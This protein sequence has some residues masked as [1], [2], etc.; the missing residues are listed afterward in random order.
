MYFFRLHF[1]SIAPKKTKTSLPYRTK[2]ERKNTPPQIK[3][4]I[5]FVRLNNKNRNHL[6]LNNTKLFTGIHGDD[7]NAMN[8]PKD[9]KPTIQEM[10]WSEWKK[11]TPTSQPSFVCLRGN[12]CIFHTYANTFGNSNSHPKEHHKS[13]TH[14][15]NELHLEQQPQCDPTKWKLTPKESS[16][17]TK[18]KREWK[19]EWNLKYNKNMDSKM[20]IPTK[21]VEKI[22][23]SFLR[24]LNMSHQVIINHFTCKKF[25]YSIEK[26][27]QQR[28]RWKKT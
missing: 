12:V 21:L 16:L 7:L 2:R 3:P 6:F 1:F 17:T 10:A 9:V 8:Y 18:I 14:I 25:K 11:H 26:T 19:W 5:L 27:K 13:Y 23:P 28:W 15:A 22:E 4:G 20:H 24:A